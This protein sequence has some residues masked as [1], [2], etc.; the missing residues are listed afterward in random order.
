[1]VSV[2]IPNYNGIEHLETC[3]ESLKNQTIDKFR[4][5][6]VDNNSKDNSVK[7]IRLYYP[8]IAILELKRNK[9]FAGAVNDGIRFSLNDPTVKYIVLLNNDI[10]CDKNF[11]IEMRKGF[12]SGDIGSVAC[13]M[14]NFYKR[15]IIDSAGD[16]VNIK[17]SPYARGHGQKDI[18]QFNQPEYVFGA[19]AGAVMYKREVFESVGFFDEDF[20]AY[21]EDVDYDLRMQLSGFKCF[22]NPR[23]ICYH[24]RGATG[25]IIDG[26]QTYMCEKN[27]PALRIK[28]YPLGLYL[29][30]QPLFLSGRIRRYYHFAV[31]NSFNLL[32]TAV[33]GYLKGLSEIPKSIRKR[34]HIQKSKKINNKYFKSLFK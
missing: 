17:G 25:K 24:K 2:I 34:I 16:F 18:G 15:N 22:Y 31:N 21:Y 12:V 20:F 26:Y 4:I 19:C 6:F 11:L 3:L 29:M 32:I 8:E 23:A 30:Y 33:K 7:F 10:E 1:M 28:N 27:L 13:K 5:I 14:L 9:G